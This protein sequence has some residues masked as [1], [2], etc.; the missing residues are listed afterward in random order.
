MDKLIGSY[1]KKS[2]SN[3]SSDSKNESIVMNW[4]TAKN[5]DKLFYYMNIELNVTKEYYDAATK[6]SL[7]PK[8]GYKPNLMEM[9]TMG[10]AYIT[11]V[12]TDIAFLQGKNKGDITDMKRVF[13]SNEYNSNQFTKLC[14]VLGL[15][16]PFDIIKAYEIER[17]GTKEPSEKIKE[18]CYE[19]LIGAI[20]LSN[21]DKCT[22]VELIAL[23]NKF[24]SFINDF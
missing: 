22:I 23:Y 24:V 18:S 3:K 13:A 16:S 14:Q 20:Y 15:S 2:S 1:T 17:Q 12:I 7:D 10:D 19:A 8:E 9:A 5:K 6:H 11:N 21:R 4:K